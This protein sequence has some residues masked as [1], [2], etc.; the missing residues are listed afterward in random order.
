MF[1]LPLCSPK[2]RERVKVPRKLPAARER[3]RRTPTKDELLLK[4]ARL[5]WFTTSIPYPRRDLGSITQQPEGVPKLPH[6][7]GWKN[8]DTTFPTGND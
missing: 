3:R 8:E 4:L 5:P 1:L 2:L 7:G 6:R